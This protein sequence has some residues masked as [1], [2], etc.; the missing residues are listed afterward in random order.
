VTGA[1]DAADPGAP[2]EGDSAGWGAALPAFGAPTAGDT[3]I[4]VIYAC[5]PGTGLCA[6]SNPPSPDAPVTL[7]W[8]NGN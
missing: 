6:A 7:P 4:H 3:T 8:T 5:V 2:H 1:S